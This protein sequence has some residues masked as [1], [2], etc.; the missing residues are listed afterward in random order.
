MTVRPAQMGAGVSASSASPLLPY[1]TGHRSFWRAAL[2]LMRKCPCAAGARQLLSWWWSAAMGICVTS[3]SP[4]SHWWKVRCFHHQHYL[5]LNFCRIF[6]ISP[7]QI[8]SSVHH[9]VFLTIMP[10]LSFTFSYILCHSVFHRLGV[11]LILVAD[12]LQRWMQNSF[13]HQPTTN[14][15]NNFTSLSMYK[16]HNCSWTVPID[17]LISWHF[18]WLKSITQY[19]N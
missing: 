18:H 2:W 11:Y 15:G 6:I 1:W 9:S 4:C 13:I 5:Y 10:L 14:L 7:Q 12:P 3:T 19:Y 8:P 16:L 17:L